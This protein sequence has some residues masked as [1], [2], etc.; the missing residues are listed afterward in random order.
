MDP[1][2]VAI[3]GSG[4]TVAVRVTESPACVIGWDEDRIMLV[5]VAFG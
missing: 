5:S 4:I 1:E 3:V 2:D